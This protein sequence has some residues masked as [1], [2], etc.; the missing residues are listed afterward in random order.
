MYIGSARP[1]DWKTDPEPDDDREP[2]TIPEHVVQILGFNPEEGFDDTQSA[3][4][5][6]SKGRK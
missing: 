5:E 4:E 3:S 2:E 1:V 6:R